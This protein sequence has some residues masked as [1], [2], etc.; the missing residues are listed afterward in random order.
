MYT[1]SKRSASF[2][3]PAV[4]LKVTVFRAFNYSC[5]WNTTKDGSGTLAVFTRQS[6]DPQRFTVSEVAVDWHD[7]LALR[8]TRGAACRHT[9]VP[10][11]R[12]IGHPHNK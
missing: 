3:F 7:I 2:R 6:R 5:E 9:T 12:I 8:W 1:K 11:C 4:I 10:V